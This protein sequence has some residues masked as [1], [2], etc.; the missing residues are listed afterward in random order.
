MGANRKLGFGLGAKAPLVP[1][2]VCSQLKRTTPLFGFL[3]I[4]TVSLR[5]ELTIYIAP[6]PKSWQ[7]HFCP[8]L[9]SA[10]PLRPLRLCGELICK[11]N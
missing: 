3:D 8:A 10:L 9:F 1:L 11:N 5:F 7:G 6:G 4:E 2:K